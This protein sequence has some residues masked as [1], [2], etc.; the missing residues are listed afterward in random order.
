M[1]KDSCKEMGLVGECDIRFSALT[2]ARPEAAE[3]PMRKGSSSWMSLLR[4][5][6]IAFLHLVFRN[7]A[8]DFGI[9][10]GVAF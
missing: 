7:S 5:F 9:L 2:C 10:G 3:I 1:R 6:G 8:V 4:G